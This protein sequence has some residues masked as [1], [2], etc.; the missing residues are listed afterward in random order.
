[1][2]KEI[3]TKSEHKYFL[4]IFI[5]FTLSLFVFGQ[6]EA[7]AQSMDPKL[8]QQYQNLKNGNSQT[9]QT[10]L[11]NS[12]RYEVLSPEEEKFYAK[13]QIAA[14]L[15]AT[16]I[17]RLEEDYQE[18][19]GDDS[20][21][22]QF[23]Y[24]I[25]SKIAPPL[26]NPAGQ[27]SDSYIL[28][29]GDELIISL[30]G[31]NDSSVIVSVDRE[32]KVV[33]PQMLPIQAMGRTLG[34]FKEDFR[35][36]VS[37]SMLGTEVFISLGK[38]RRIT[39]YVLGEVSLPGL[40]SV[41]SL[42]T[43]LQALSSAGGIKKTGSLRN[44]K[45]ISN[46]EIKFLDI[47]KL[48][49]NGRGANISL[50]DGARI[51]VP[52]IGDTV[53]VS[54]QV[55]REGIFE[56]EN[57][58]QEL[59][60]K[61]LMAL[62]GGGLR[63][64]GN[65]Y[66]LNHISEEGFQKI[67]SVNNLDDMIVGSDILQ[68]Y[69]KSGMKVGEV[70]LS[71]HFRVPGKRPLD[72]SKTISQLFSGNG[73]DLLGATPYLPLAILETTDDSSKARIYK[74]INLED[75]LAGIEDVAL[76]NMDELFILSSSDVEFL[77]DYVIRK[78]IVTGDAG[79]NSCPSLL[80][81]AKFVTSGDVSRFSAVTRSI[82]ASGEDFLKK[83][84]EVT[85][86]IDEET[87]NLSDG[88]TLLSDDNLSR[89]DVE[90]P[91]GLEP[92]ND[93]DILVCNLFFDENVRLLPFTLENAISTIGSVRRPG[94]YPVAGS[95]NLST[96][97]SIAGG[98]SNTADLEDI[99]VINFLGHKNSNFSGKETINSMVTAMS[100]VRV[101][102]GS[103]VRV[104][105]LQTN[106][107]TGTVLVTGEFV[108][109]GIYSI[110]RGEKLSQ[111]FE[112]AGGLTEFAYPYGAVMTKV[113]VKKQQ[114]EAFRRA[115]RE[116]DSALAVAAVRANI[117]AGTLVAAQQLSRDLGSVEAMGRVVIEADPTV[118]RIKSNLDT[119]LDGGDTINMPKRPNYITVSGDVL[120]PGALQFQPGFKVKQYLSQT[121]GYGRSADKK[122][123][124][125]VLPNGVSEPLQKSFWSS[126][127]VLLPPGATIIVPKNLK[128]Y[129]NLDVFSQL[130]QIIGQLSL[131]AASVAV[132]SK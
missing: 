95:V 91:L 132:I 50:E 53:S 45:I 44:I 70:I 8:L 48:L 119:T 30:V 49:E 80:H 75:I 123:V 114:E 85:Q 7:T 62:S 58:V 36:Q 131:S 21:I 110:F 88:N 101:P 127:E 76:K 84:N 12:S 78:M 54:G 125:V 41:T 51:I 74:A 24:D 47:Y 4:S 96:I 102:S 99:E 81:L 73:I 46:G 28:G 29:V 72:V 98:F 77:S 19:I 42:S 31:S 86:I 82:F 52:T 26:I 11:L 13:A 103:S 71:G 92:V 67:S 57:G 118:L 113:S 16:T 128:T 6:F 37:A 69:Y 109:P 63:L 89:N 116:I 126:A 105:Q 43:V 65:N 1:M 106:Q 121:G 18:R 79:E 64:R 66:L 83:S 40:Q 17:S 115:S 111:L 107:E 87:Q 22:S 59:S 38:I 122:R 27:I 23:G 2:L 55:V 94:V 9:N 108:R 93:E 100:S 5:L 33:M 32:G 68:V 120:N 112:R 60:V 15:N 104:N 25:F 130:A 20:S 14:E 10:S 129:S 56:L 117:E 39:I 124:Y 3:N 61:A 97:I 35:T 90:D 34:S